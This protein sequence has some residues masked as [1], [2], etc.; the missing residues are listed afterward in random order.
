MT[1]SSVRS[2]SG[3]V[4]HEPADVGEARLQRFLQ[5]EDQRP[6]GDQTR[7]LVV[8]P[9]A[10]ERADPEVLLEG[11]DG[12]RRVERP[13]GPRDAALR[14][15]SCPPHCVTIAA[16][17]SAKIASAAF[18]RASSSAQACRG[19]V[20]RRERAGREIDPGQA[21]RVSLARHD[22]DEVVG[23]PRV[24]QPVVGDGARRDDAGHLAVDDL[25]LGVGLLHLLA[26]GDAVAGAEE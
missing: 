16:A 15:G 4:R 18:S 6:G 14:Q 13:V 21:E 7:L 1:S 17:C 3:A 9:E 23:R 24:E 12:G 11:I 20:G 19:D 22:R 8:E 10:G 5:V 26:D 2:A 25:L